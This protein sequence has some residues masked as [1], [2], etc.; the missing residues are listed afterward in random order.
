M[1]YFFGNNCLTVLFYQQF[2]IYILLFF[3]SLYMVP[4]FLFLYFVRHSY[5]DSHLLLYYILPTFNPTHHTS[6]HLTVLWYWPRLTAVVWFTDAWS[7]DEPQGKAQ[8]CLSGNCEF[9]LSCWMTSGLIQGSC[10]GFLYACCHRNT[11]KAGEHLGPLAANEA[12]LP[13]NLGPV[14]ND[15]SKW[16]T[17]TSPYLLYTLY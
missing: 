6:F 1:K 12:P 2:Y 17:L 8:Q 11:A 14:V 15:P 3:N 4:T 16:L 13:A 5:L 9:F 10:G 7:T